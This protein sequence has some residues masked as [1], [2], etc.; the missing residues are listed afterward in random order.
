MSNC[1]RMKPVESDN[2]VS[3]GYDES[4]QV[5]IIEFNKKRLYRYEKVPESLY[6]DLMKAKSKGAFFNMYIRGK[7][8]D[9]EITEES[10]K[11]FQ[12]D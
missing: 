4:S 9:K 8:K 1:L 5:L 12:T 11:K 3:V 6:V 10:L 2:L 7:F